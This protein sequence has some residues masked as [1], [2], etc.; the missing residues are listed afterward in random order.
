MRDARERMFSRFGR[1]GSA[2]ARTP[3]GPVAQLAEQQTLNLLV[4]GSIPSGLT[5]PRQGSKR[6]ALTS[7]AKRLRLRPRLN[8]VDSFRAHHSTRPLA[9]G[10][11]KTRSCRATPR[12]ACA[13]RPPIARESKG[14]FSPEPARSH[15]AAR[16]QAAGPSHEGP[17]TGSS[18]AGR[19]RASFP[20]RTPEL[21]AE[22][23]RQPAALDGLHQI[24]DCVEMRL[25]QGS[26]VSQE[27]RRRSSQP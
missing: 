8:M 13:E 5:T 20:G 10:E 4:E 23:L 24:G 3:S 26:Q 27:L 2:G 17:L 21:R 19:C 6:L 9:S 7:S 11:Q 1:E 18:V 14:Q 16:P 12:V 25:P 15:I 22:I